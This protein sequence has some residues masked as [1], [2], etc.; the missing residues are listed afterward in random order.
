[1]K[2]QPSQPAQAQVSIGNEPPPFRIEDLHLEDLNI[3]EIM[4]FETEKS[5]E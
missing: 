5:E 4:A 3:D 1:M 2:N